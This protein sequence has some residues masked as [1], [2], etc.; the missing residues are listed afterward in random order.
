MNNDDDALDRALDTIEQVELI[1]LRWGYVDGSFAEDEIERLLAAALGSDAPVDTV[2]DALLDRA[3]LHEIPQP[4]GTR[5]YRSRFAESV[6]LFRDLK[7]LT[8]K[9]PW[10]SAP[11][12]VSDY[13]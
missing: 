8:F 4:N 1:S 3:L 2:F 11:N 12:L 13:R 10:L 6:R 7:L 5:R 9:R